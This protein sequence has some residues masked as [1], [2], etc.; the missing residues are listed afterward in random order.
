MKT[1]GYILIA[2]GFLVGAFFSV[3]PEVVWTYVSIGLAAG[4]A[5]VVMV[6]L[7]ERQRVRESATLEGGIRPLQ[8]ALDRLAEGVRGLNARKRDLDVYS[9]HRRIDE[10]F[11]ADQ[12]VFVEGRESIAHVY[13]LQAYAE[14]M[15]AFAAGERY[16]NRVWSSSIDGYVDEAHEYLDR[17]EEQFT[18]AQAKLRGLG[19]SAEL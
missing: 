8:E 5:G 14:V 9:L 3:L 11:P 15:S 18:E 19:S 10:L 1:T 7:G 17:A 4:V 16:L 6:R 12:A 13:S 2:A